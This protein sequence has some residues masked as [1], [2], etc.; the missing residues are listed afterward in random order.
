M[1]GARLTASENAENRRQELAIER[2][3]QA[4][5]MEQIGAQESGALERARLDSQ[6]NFPQLFNAIN[7]AAHTVKFGA[8]DPA[9]AEEALRQLHQ[10]F[11]E[12]M[13]LSSAMSPG[14]SA[15]M[16]MS[17]DELTAMFVPI[18]NSLPNG[19][20]STDEEMRGAVQRYLTT[21]NPG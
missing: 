15:I 1:A 7:E 19:L 5:A 6:A 18:L 12:F 17:E 14:R 2:I 20:D 3:R 8:E 9:R 21:Q 11:Y 4:G 13:D 10:M 16:R